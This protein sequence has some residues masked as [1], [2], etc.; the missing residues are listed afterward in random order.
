MSD[1]ESL[2]CSVNCLTDS[3]NGIHCV[4]CRI[5]KLQNIYDTVQLPLDISNDSD[6]SD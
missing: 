6:I 1:V 4:K 3:D 5:C 2:R